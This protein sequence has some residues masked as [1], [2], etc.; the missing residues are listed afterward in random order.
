M[1]ACVVQSVDRGMCEGRNGYA[2]L[3]YNE[4]SEAVGN[5]DQWSEGE[6]LQALL[7]MT[8]WRRTGRPEC[9]TFLRRLSDSKS[10]CA[11]TVVF[12]FIASAPNH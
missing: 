9:S 2:D 12:C 4:P 3:Q 7:A 8:V 1:S 10:R 5:D 6:L 11:T